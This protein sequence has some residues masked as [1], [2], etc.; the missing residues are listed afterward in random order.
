MLLRFT[1]P[2]TL[3]RRNVID[4]LA[5]PKLLEFG[6]LGYLY[7]GDKLSNARGLSPMAYFQEGVLRWQSHWRKLLSREMEW[8]SARAGHI[9]VNSLYIK[10]SI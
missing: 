8:R 5:R 6:A 4:W 7:S 1:I 2:G 9:P 3:F 10:N